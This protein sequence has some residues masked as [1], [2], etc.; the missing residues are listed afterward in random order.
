M[1]VKNIRDMLCGPPHPS[2]AVTLQTL[3]AESPAERAIIPQ[4]P[5]GFTA[6]LPGD[7]EEDHPLGARV[8]NPLPGTSVLELARKL[9]EGTL[10][11]TT[12]KAARNYLDMFRKMTGE[13]V[14]DP[15]NHPFPEP[16]IEMTHHKVFGPGL[17]KLRR[18]DRFPNYESGLENVMD[19]ISQNPRPQG[20]ESFEIQASE[21]SSP[22]QLDAT[23]EEAVLEGLWST[24]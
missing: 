17:G 15:R 12:E 5:S 1:S 10:D 20:D 16:P 9:R 3:A 11:L 8:T 24:R 6:R 19:V 13:V 7:P 4:G 23:N 2:E 18:A 22:I 14:Y 21:S